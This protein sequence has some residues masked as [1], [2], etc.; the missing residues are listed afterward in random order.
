MLRVSVP[1]FIRD[2]K[3]NVATIFALSVI[4]C[5]FLTGM[6]LDFAGATQKRV[7][8]N[9]A[10]DAAALAAVTPTAMGQTA[11]VW[12][13]NPCCQSRGDMGRP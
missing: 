5:V 6:G 7:I 4:P 2:R 1:R 11:A 9:A 13:T 12:T 3:G 10:A 8:L